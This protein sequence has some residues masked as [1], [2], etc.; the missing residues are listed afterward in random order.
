MLAVYFT[1]RAATD[2]LAIQRQALAEQ[3]AAL[4]AEARRV[5]AAA[6]EAQ[7]KVAAAELDPVE[8]LGTPPAS[9]PG[10]P[11]DDSDSDGDSGASDASSSG[12][13][14]QASDASEKSV[15]AAAAAAATAAQAAKQDQRERDDAARRER[16]NAEREA[17]RAQ[18]R[19]AGFHA[20]RHAQ[21]LA[22]LLESSG[23]NTA[24]E[25]TDAEG[26]GGLDGSFAPDG[27]RSAADGTDG[28]DALE[29]SA[30]T[31]R[32]CAAAEVTHFFKRT[33]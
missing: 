3:T 20:G 18:D 28:E 32:L 26:R 15:D 23:C 9:P 10:S 25:E 6:V 11:K 27:E 16:E 33:I 7:G 21:S 29:S 5:A 13:D 4:H 14:S 1:L 12:G 30:A 31:L 8:P 17:R 22:A 24:G 19:A 2:E